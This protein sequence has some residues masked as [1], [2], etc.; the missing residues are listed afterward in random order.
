[1]DGAARRRYSKGLS[2]LFAGPMTQRQPD[3]ASPAR[4]GALATLPVFFRLKGRKV[5]LAGGGDGAA[6]KAEL[7]AATGAQVNVFSAEPSDKMRATVDDLANVEWIARN[8]DAADLADA[9]LAVGDV[10]SDEE[11]QNFHD[12]A[13][14]QGVPVNVVDRPAFCD[15]QFG[16]IVE[17]SPVVIGISTDGAA[18]VFGQEIRARIE[19]ILPHGLRVWAQAAKVW[20]PAVLAKKFDFRTRRSFWERFTALAFTKAD[21]QPRETDLA[22]LLAAVESSQTDGPR[23]SVAL[24]GAGPGDPDLLTVK[25]VRAL[26]SADVVLYDDL[27]SPR[28]VNAARREATRIA[29]GKRGYKPSCTQEDITAMLVSL[30]REGKRVVR[31]KGG[32]PMIFGRAGEEIAGVIDAGIPIDIIPGVTAASGAAASLGLSLTERDVA[33]RVQFITA[34]G[35]NGKL[36]D[37]LALS[38]LTDP[39]ATTV[40]Y[41]GVKT[42][43]LLVERLLAEGLD[44]ATPAIVVERATWP[45]ERRI[46]DT[47][48]HM[49][50]RIREA[51]TTGPCLVLIGAALGGRMLDARNTS[52]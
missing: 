24:V 20:R 23:G 5:V 21:E 7:L 9:A 11:A 3:Q 12:A 15:F 14:A 4:L 33:R 52:A 35:R 46:A 18:P 31:L 36:P 51:Q 19:S 8:W 40:V 47:I 22:D 48:A 10:E 34:H 13:R 28:T 16:S 43:P 44:P 1:M 27:V 6:W 45:D 41:M 32:D 26:Q 30:A 2:Q 39:R 38:A 17:R 25:A 42:L 29:V 37:D 49:P 50:Q